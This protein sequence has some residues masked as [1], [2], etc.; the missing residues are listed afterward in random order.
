MVRAQ[1]YD[2][3][4]KRG[5]G[6]VHP[7]DVDRVTDVGSCSY[8]KSNNMILPLSPNKSI[9]RIRA[10]QTFLSLINFIEKS[11]NIYIIKWAPYENAFYDKFNYTNLI[12]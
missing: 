3:G 10:S 8:T 1:A 9:P 2:S 5:R 6:H 4:D 7:D 11:N 12:P